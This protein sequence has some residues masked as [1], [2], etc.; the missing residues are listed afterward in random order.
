MK[1]V[2]HKHF[3]NNKSE[4]NS[5]KINDVTYTDEYDIFQQFKDYFSTIDKKEH[6]TDTSTNEDFSN[7]RNES[8]STHSI[9]F[10]RVSVQESENEIMSL[11]SNRSHIS[12]YSD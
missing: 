11:K 7:Y 1:S 5:I 4:M 6:E 12:T 3:V 2:L 10:Y 8:Q 9:K